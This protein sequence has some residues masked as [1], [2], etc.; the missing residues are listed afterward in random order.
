MFDCY[1]TKVNGF[2]CFHFVEIFKMR[3]H[4]N[5]KDNHHSE[6]YSLSDATRVT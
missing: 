6:D 2:A 3:S 4:L 1:Q 5:S